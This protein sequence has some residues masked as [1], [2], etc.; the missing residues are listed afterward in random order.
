MLVDL[1]IILGKGQ[2]NYYVC[3]VNKNITTMTEAYLIEILHSSYVE[4]KC[5]NCGE[6]FT[7][8]ETSY[9]AILKQVK[10]GVKS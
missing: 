6:V 4:Y 8:S 5:P 7:V 2:I 3:T 9:S 1:K 10:D